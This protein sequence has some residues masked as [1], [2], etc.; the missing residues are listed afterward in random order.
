MIDVQVVRN[1][2]D[3]VK[4]KAKQKGV[5]V[6][7]DEFLRL[8]KERKELLLTVEDLRKRRNE[9]AD[10]M[11]GGKPADELI[12]EGRE[13]K[14][15]LSKRE[16]YLKETDEKWQKL[17][18]SIPNMPVDDV[19]VGAT[20][21]ENVVVREWGDKPSFDFDIK[22]H[23]E[24]AESKGWLDKERGAKVAGSRFVYLKGDL[25]ML[26]YA[27]WNFGL[28]VLTDEKILQKL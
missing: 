25:V 22:N 28:N 17:L 6:D 16:D 9:I 7:V 14:I 4:E 1:N 20:E 5:E 10:S 24:I 21:D 15:E 12:E 27:L 23:A 8:D 19:P 2:P 13:I 3:L 11:K 18:S 26:E